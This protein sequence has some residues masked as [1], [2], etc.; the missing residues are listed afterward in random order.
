LKCF[1][2]SEGFK[3]SSLVFSFLISEGYLFIS[4]EIV[5]IRILRTKKLSDLPCSGK[6]PMTN[7]LKRAIERNYNFL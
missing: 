4:G 6:Q 1:S 2:I 7:M 3:N 5:K